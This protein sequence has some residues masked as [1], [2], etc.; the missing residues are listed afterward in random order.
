MEMIA[1]VTKGVYTLLEKMAEKEMERDP[2]EFIR[3]E[4]LNIKNTEEF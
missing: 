3:N 2:L 1:E 4:S